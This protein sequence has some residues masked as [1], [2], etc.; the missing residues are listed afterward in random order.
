MLLSEATRE[1]PTKRP[2]DGQSRALGS[3]AAAKRRC[4]AF[5]GRPVPNVAF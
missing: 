1:A 3:R 2:A 5:E 4:G